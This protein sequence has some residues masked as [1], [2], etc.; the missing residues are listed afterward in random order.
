M[1]THREGGGV[2]AGCV[3]R[4]PDRHR[5]EFATTD[6]DRARTYL[7]AAY[8]TMLTIQRDPATYR[9]RHVR[10]DPGPFHLDTMEHQATTEFRGRH[11]MPISVVR[12]HRGLRTD[13]VHD[14][15]FGPG[16]LVLQA[17]ADR[18][19]HLRQE[20]FLGSLVGIA[21]QAIAEAAGNRPEEPLPPLRFT[22]RR[23][24]HP[25]DARRWL[26]V[27]DYVTDSLNTA[28]EFIT[29]PL[30]IG[31]MTRLLAAAVLTTFPNTYIPEACYQDRTD[32]TPAAVTRATA[33]IEANADIDISVID[34]ARAARVSVRAVRRAFRRHLDTTPMA[35]LRRVRL[36]RAH[37]QLGDRVPGDGTTVADIA[38]R[39]GYADLSRFTADYHRAYG[40][41]LG[42]ALDR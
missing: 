9:L 41:P 29:H 12:V 13:L 39:W 31:P 35:Y 40:R 37:Q 4:D 22:A 8:D 3:F 15:R 18:P 28:A 27:V 1:T 42:R 23:P 30:M 7:T 14:D 5:I 20:S 25:A 16:D 10:L 36:D 2:P 19:C 38:A 6:P 33:F 21:P 24:A 34:M 11:F 26:Y 17:D 32:A